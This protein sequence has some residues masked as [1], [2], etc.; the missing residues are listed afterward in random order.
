MEPG[1]D[2]SPKSQETCQQ[3]CVDLFELQYRTL[4]GS[5][6]GLGHTPILING[7]PR[8]KAGLSLDTV[9]LISTV[10]CMAGVATWFFVLL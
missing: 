3:V 4:E 9:V 6:Q 2:L 5:R 1:K 10:E 8:Y 7:G